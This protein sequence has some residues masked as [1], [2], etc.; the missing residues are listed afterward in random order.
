MKAIITVGIPCS[1]KTQWAENVVANNEG[2]TSINRDDIRF[3]TFCDGN[4]DWSKYK[5][6]KAREKRV[7][8]IV[9]Q[10]IAL[11]W[12]YRGNVIISDTNLNPGHKAELIAHLNSVGYKVEEKLFPISLEEACKRDALR[13]NGVGKDVIYTMYRK[14]IDQYG[15]DKYVPN[16]NLSQAVI[17]DVDG[18][19]ADMKGVRGPFDWDK[20]D[21]DKTID[22]VLDMLEG[23][24]ML[25]YTIILLSGRDGSCEYKTRAWLSENCPFYDELFMRD[26]GDCRRDIIIKKE[27]FYDRVAPR[28]NVV[29]VVDDR[30]SVCRMWRDLGLNV[31]QVG[32]PYREF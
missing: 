2:W 21:Q 7:T 5:F 25:G 12:T 8:Q 19:I 22:H 26:A 14:W 24:H 11:A 10:E 3:D 9:C 23:Y 15:E 13:A 17:F 16:E 32:D 27:L 18:T 30:P 1:G 6:T 29:A 20:V 4:H 28:Y 31:V